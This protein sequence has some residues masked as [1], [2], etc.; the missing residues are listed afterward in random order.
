MA[1]PETINHQDY[2]LT[3]NI[4][5]EEPVRHPIDGYD[6]Q[7]LFLDA[8]TGTWVR[9]EVPIDRVGLAAGT[10]LE[11]FAF[12]QYGGTVFWDDAG[13]LGP[14]PANLIAPIVTTEPAH[15]DP[16]QAAILREVFRREHSPR[17]AAL[18][19]EVVAVDPKRYHPA[20]AV[21]LGGPLLRHSRH[22][23]HGQADSGRNGQGGEQG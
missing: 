6:I 14:D 23:G 16:A 10:T 11:G 5:D 15:R 13:I 12:T 4:H 17:Y 21:E 9:L 2:L 18:E 20:M 22:T 7:P 19:A 3:V 8:E 1:L